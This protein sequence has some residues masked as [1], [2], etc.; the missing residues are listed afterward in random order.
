MQLMVQRI[1]DMLVA[2]IMTAQPVTVTLDD[3]LRIA[4][5]RM[6]NFSCRRLPV[7][8]KH[9][10]L[11]GIITDRDTR[12]ALHSPFVLGEEEH[13]QVILDKVT[14]R[15]VMTAAPITVQPNTDIADAI[16][17]MVT[18]RIGGLPVLRGET[19]VGIVTSTDVM[20]AFVRHLRYS[21]ARV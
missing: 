3:P 12:L 15:S 8:N 19:L 7:V 13:N 20:T 1:L 17:L 5:E 18:H 21:E 2:D 16:S 11:V 14:I 4:V 6:R 10:D 9:G